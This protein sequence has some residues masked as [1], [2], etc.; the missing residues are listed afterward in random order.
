[1]SG[2]AETAH[3]VWRQRGA[4]LVDKIGPSIVMTHSA[5]GSFG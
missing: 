2:G 4:M 3:M 5:G 1:V